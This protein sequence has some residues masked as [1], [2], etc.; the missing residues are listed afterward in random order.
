MW[1][2]TRR[3]HVDG[4]PTCWRTDRT[5]DSTTQLAASTVKTRMIRRRRRPCPCPLRCR[6]RHRR[7]PI[8]T[9]RRSKA[10]RRRRR[11]RPPTEFT[12]PS[13]CAAPTRSWR[14][15]TRAATLLSSIRRRDVARAHTSLRQSRAATISCATGSSASPKAPASTNAT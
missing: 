4:T 5:A 13:L 2:S 14:S 7:H 1:L 11:P 15:T 10:T 12:W 6:H 3:R 9:T 8:R